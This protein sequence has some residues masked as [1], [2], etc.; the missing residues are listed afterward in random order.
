MADDQGADRRPAGSDGGEKQ[1]ELQLAGRHLA[2]AVVGLA[3]FG[4]VLFLLGRWTERVGR[5][6]SPLADAVGEETA[7]PPPEEVAENP[8]AGPR[9]LTF[10]ETLG[11]KATPGLNGT[12]DTSGRREPPAVLPGSPPPPTSAA[13]KASGPSSGESASGERYKVQVVATRDG[14]AAR[15]L[16]E[17]LQKKGYQARVETARDARG[18]VQYKVRVGSFS[19][20]EPA[21]RMAARIRAEER[22]GAW[23]VK[24][25]S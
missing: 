23:I 15:G 10:Y 6:T 21:E 9:E 1:V 18:R 14:T 20:R 25:Q 4:L 11:K 12:P 7:P 2:L 16:A 17:R 19:D 22:V 13:K 8:L 5:P 3:L 24:V